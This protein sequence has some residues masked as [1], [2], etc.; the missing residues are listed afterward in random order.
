[1]SNM[2]SE[3]VLRFIGETEFKEGVWAGVELGGG[4]KGKGKN[5]GSVNGCVWR[6]FPTIQL[7]K[8]ANATLTLTRIAVSLSSTPSY[9]HQ[10]PYPVHQGQ[11]VWLRRIG[12]I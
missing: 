10:R 8:T 1:M 2:G 7:T 12:R 11:R 5:D 4:F 6:L 3:G 9:H